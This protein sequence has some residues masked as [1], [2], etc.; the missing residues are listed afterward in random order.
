MNKTLLILS[1]VSIGLVA[2]SEAVSVF[3]A[4]QTDASTTTNQTAPNFND[5]ASTP[6]ITMFAGS[7]GA[8]TQYPGTGGA[9]SFS[10]NGVTYGGSGGS[11]TDGRSLQWSVAANSNN[12]LIGSGFTVSNINLTNLQDLTMRFDIRSASGL[13]SPAAPTTFTSIEYSLNGGSSWVDITGSLAVPTWVGATSSPFSVEDVDFSSIAAIEGQS[14]VSLRFVFSNGGTDP[15]TNQN[16]RLD[17]L[18][19]SAVPEPSTLAL[20]G[21]LG[22]AGMVRRKRA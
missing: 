9:S 10:Y 1:A 15:T 22:I 11:G 13:T 14:N 19:F 18:L 12:S 8:S 16:I 4:F 6:V 21:V 17:N 2:S 20:V 5:M 7:D 3:W